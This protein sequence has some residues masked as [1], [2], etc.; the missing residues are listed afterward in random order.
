LDPH[1][2]DRSSLA[3]V[4]TPIADAV[5]QA[6][7]NIAQATALLTGIDPSALPSDSQARFASFM[8]RL[9]QVKALI[10]HGHQAVAFLGRLVGTDQP[11]RYLLLFQ[12]SSEL[13]P[14]G[15]F[16]GSY[17]LITFEG[18]RIKSLAADDIYNPDGQIKQLVVPPL[19][20]QH[21]TPSWGMRDANWFIDFPTSARKVAEYYRKGGGTAVDGVIAIRP[22]IL[23]QILRVTGPVSLPQYDLMLTADNFLESV[24]LQVESQKSAA[25][26]KQIIMDL[27]P[28]ILGRLSSLPTDQWM[29]ILDV[30]QKGLARRDMLMYLD[31]AQM[32]AYAAAQNWDGRVEDASGDYLTVNV[33]NVKGAK[34]DAVTDTSLKLETW[35]ESGSLVHRLTVTRAHNGGQSAYGFYNKTNYSYVR[36]LVPKGSTLRGVAGNDHPFNRPMVDY[37]KVPAIRDP[38]LAALEQTYQYDPVQGETTFEESGKTGFGFWMRIEPGQAQTVQLEYAIPARAAAS[39]YHLYIQRQPGLD[40]SDFEFTLQKGG[41]VRSVDSD[42]PLIEWP[43]SWRLHDQLKEDLDLQIVLH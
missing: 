11:R 4:L 7:A 10:E 43:D 27:A 17:G 18:G 29:Q 41:S 6:D 38:D 15:G 13:R 5:D 37:N 19:Q 30:F 26:P 23:Q 3:Q 25:E 20:L 36:V 39:D 1:A 42:H 33:A 8:E 34:A 16:P 9:P 12:N 40:I 14:T 2:D 24:Q 35:S 32:Q 22:E 28:I 31:D 21:I